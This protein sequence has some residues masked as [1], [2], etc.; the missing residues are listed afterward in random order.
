VA[1]GEGLSRRSR[2]SAPAPRRTGGQREE[3]GSWA[4]A[5]VRDDGAIEGVG[6]GAIR[7]IH[8]HGSG[9]EAQG[10]GGTEGG[11]G[12]E[13]QGRGSADGGGR[14]GARSLDRDGP[15]AHPGSCTRAHALG[16]TDGSGSGARRA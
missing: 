11:G 4:G 7:Q 1:G 12:G 15:C 2:G 8:D 9:G 16:G 6:E 3:A 5:C 10:H 13:A 14:G